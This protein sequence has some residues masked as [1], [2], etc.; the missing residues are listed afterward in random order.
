M[1]KKKIP[2]FQILKKY[3]NGIENPAATSF[4]EFNSLY[5]KKKKNFLKLTLWPKVTFSKI[6]RKF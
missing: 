3:K 1:I 5:E 2:F 6:C 4:R